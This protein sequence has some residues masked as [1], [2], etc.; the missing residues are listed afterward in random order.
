MKTCLN[1]AT[2]MPYSFEDDV[3]LAAANGFDGVEIWAEK[4][5]KYLEDHSPSEV[6]RL[7]DQHGVEATGWCSAPLRYFNDV[8]GAVQAFRETAELAH[9]LGVQVLLAIPDRPPED[10]SREQAIEHAGKVGK[11][12]TPMLE[13]FDLRFVVEPKPT[14]FLVPH[15]RYAVEIVEHV[16]H[17]RFGLMMDTFHYHR[18]GVS[19]EEIWAI[20]IEKLFIVHVADAEDRPR[21]EL[22]DFLRLYP[23]AGVAP[24]VEMLQVVQQKGYNGY[25]SVEIFREEYWQRPAETI[26]IE[27]KRHLDEVLKK[28]I[29]NIHEHNLTHNKSEMY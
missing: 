25:Y 6:R 11:Q 26:A 28:V 3:K 2:L 16:N 5:A 10:W 1:G 4:L 13:E 22:D 17:E 7:L 18:A 23:G 21:E 14:N 20:P 12:Y 8:E 27:A 9:T 24:L 19:R 15:P 29:P